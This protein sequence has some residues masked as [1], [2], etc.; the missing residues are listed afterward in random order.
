VLDEV[1]GAVN[2]TRSAAD[3][4]L[5]ESEAVEV[6]AVNLRQ[7]VENFLRSVAV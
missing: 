1:T 3:T 2:K 6:A 4:V 5:K 7:R